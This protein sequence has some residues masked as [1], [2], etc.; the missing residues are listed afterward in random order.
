MDSI[1]RLRILAEPLD[2]SDPSRTAGKYGDGIVDATRID[3]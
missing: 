1:A 2:R 3:I